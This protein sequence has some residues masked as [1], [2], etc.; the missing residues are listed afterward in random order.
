M[1]PTPISS[2]SKSSPIIEAEAAVQKKRKKVG[3]DTPTDE[4]PERLLEKF[5][6]KTG[7]LPKD[8]KQKPKRRSTICLP[9][10]PKWTPPRPPSA[11]I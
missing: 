4:I 8:V 9:P 11:E 6:E 7:K 5:F 10:P 1:T 2:I 3:Y